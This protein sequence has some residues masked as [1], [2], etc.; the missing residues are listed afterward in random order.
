MKNKLIALLIASGATG[1]YASDNNARTEGRAGSAYSTGDFIDGAQLNPSLAANFKDDDDFA[2][3]FNFG[4]FATDPDELIDNGSDLVDL[5]DEYEYNKPLYEDDAYEMIQLLDDISGANAYVS[6]GASLAFAIPNNT[7][8][9]TVFTRANVNASIVPLIDESD[10][11]TLATSAGN[12]FDSSDLNSEVAIRGSVI[13][14]VG[15]ALAKEINITETGQ[16]LWGVTP[17]QVEAETFF[18]IDSIGDFDEDNIDE[19]EQSISETFFNVDAG[20]TYINGNLRYAM[21]VNNLLEQEVESVALG[22]KLSIKPQAIASVG[23]S[24]NW[25]NLDASVELNSAKNYALI[26][27]TQIA[28]VGVEFGSH[29]WARLRLGYKTDIKSSLE[30]TFSLGLGLAPFDVVNFDWALTAGDKN[31]FGTSLQLGFRF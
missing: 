4:V 20:V 8:A 13:T 15:V 29:T 26:D 24:L 31:T 12:E 30:D 18:Y 9:A 6:G 28:R 2:F 23:Y 7:L 17:K 21:V 5:L 25:V 11:D 19:D 22:E 14:E 10:F 3:H 16:W 1:A 27:D